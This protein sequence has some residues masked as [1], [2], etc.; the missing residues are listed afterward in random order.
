MFVPLH[1]DPVLMLAGLREI[2][3]R[4]QAQPVIGVRPACFIQPNGHFRRYAGLAAQDTR[5]SMAGTP[6]AFAPSVT[7]RP[8]GSRQA[9]LME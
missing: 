5:E 6:S 7:V 4:L 3:G 8:R 1:L 2:V 9:S